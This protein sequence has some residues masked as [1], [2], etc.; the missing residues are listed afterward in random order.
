MY[1]Y[2]LFKEDI[3]TGLNGVVNGVCKC[4]L[5]RVHWNLSHKK[6]NCS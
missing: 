6:N 5:N 1:V 4:I 2:I 3:L